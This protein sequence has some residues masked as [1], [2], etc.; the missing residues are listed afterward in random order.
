MKT[1]KMKNDPWNKWEL[2]F[3][4]HYLKYNPRENKRLTQVLKDNGFTIEWTEKEV[5]VYGRR[6]EQ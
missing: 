2:V 4:G 6:H 3:A 5:K 1:E